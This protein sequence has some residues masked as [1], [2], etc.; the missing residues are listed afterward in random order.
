MAWVRNIEKVR[1]G[2]VH[3]YTHEYELASEVFIPGVLNYA[4]ENILCAFLT[5]R[6]DRQGLYKYLL[7]LKATPQGSSVNFDADEKGYLFIDGILGELLALF[8]VFFQCRFYLVNSFSFELTPEGPKIKYEFDPVYRPCH[9]TLDPWVL[10]GSQRNFARGLPDFLDQVFEMK[11]KY[12][13]RFILACHHYSRALKE[14]GIDEEMEFIR[15][16]S[17]IEALCGDVILQ[18]SDDPFQGKRFEDIVRCEILSDSERGELKKI[19]D[20]R[21]AKKRFKY[22]I[23]MYS[24]G[25]FKGGRSKAPYARIRKADLPRKLDAIYN[26]RSGYLHSGE[27]MHLSRATCGKLRWDTEPVG[28]TIIDNRR[29]REGTRL[30]CASFFQRLVRY[31]LLQYFHDVRNRDS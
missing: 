1:E 14:I 13:Q 25:F 7:R 26:A 22:F 15:L 20:V 23:H 19:F 5:D 2:N 3:T 17:A 6:K 27:P 18:E 29:I 24:K 31:C 4:E 28:A 30:P 11:M 12:H 21:K 10:S 8:S 9:Q 16:V